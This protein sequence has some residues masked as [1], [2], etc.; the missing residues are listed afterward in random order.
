MVLD[1]LIWIKNKV[2]SALTFRRSC[3]RYYEA[4]RAEFQD[5]DIVHARQILFQVTT[6]AP[7]TA[8][9]CISSI[10]RTEWA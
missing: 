3:R 7:V 6:G 2:D 5:G 1:A 4:H 9:F 8:V 10:A